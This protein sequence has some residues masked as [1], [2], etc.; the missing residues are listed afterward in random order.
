MGI[1]L[2]QKVRDV[3]SGL[4]GIAICRTE[5]LAGCVRITVQP[6]VGRDGKLPDAQTVDEQQL[7]VLTKE[8]ID[9]PGNVI[10]LGP[11]EVRR[12]GGGR[13]DPA[14]RRDPR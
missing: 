5:W 1:R 3:T 7:E 10:E 9:L 4:K 12:A 11:Q 8:P 14:P 13:P 2:G 6:P